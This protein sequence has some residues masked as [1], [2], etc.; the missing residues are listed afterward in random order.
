MSATRSWTVLELLRS[1]QGYFEQNG[2][3]TARLDAECLLAH[4]RGTDRLRLYIDYEE[5]VG[6]DE[7]ARLRELVRRRA[8]ERVPVAQLGQR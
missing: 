6:D 5:R 7:R 8:S 3:E 2:I 4:V 1:A